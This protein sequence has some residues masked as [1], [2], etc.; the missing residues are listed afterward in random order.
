ME[1]V[2]SNGNAVHKCWYKSYWMDYIHNQHPPAVWNQNGKE[3][4]YKVFKISYS[5]LGKRKWCYWGPLLRIILCSPQPPVTGSESL[6]LDN[7]KWAQNSRRQ[8][9]LVY[10][11]SHHLTIWYGLDCVPPK[12]ICW[13]FYDCIWSPGFLGR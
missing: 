3:N 9:W 12:F 4:R 13:D 2:F 1:Y 6:E 7:L 8:N 10:S 5:K 11:V